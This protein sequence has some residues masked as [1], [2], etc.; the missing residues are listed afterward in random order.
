MIVEKKDDKKDDDSTEI[1][2]SKSHTLFKETIS[3]DK[4]I[5]EFDNDEILYKITPAFTKYRIFIDSF[6]EDERGLHEIFN[7]LWNADEK[8]EL[9]LRINSWGGIVKEG[10]NFF[11]II[12]NKFNGRTTTVLDSAGYSMG[13]LMFCSG[14][15]R[16]ATENCDLMF[17]DY[18]GFAWGKGGEI[19]D[20]VNHTAQHLRK[21]FKK[22]IVDQGFLSKKE[23][24]QMIIGK[25]YWMDVQEMCER[26]IATHVLV[27]GEEVKAKKY[28]KK[29]AKGNKNVKKKK[30][31]SKK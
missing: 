6:D 20:S 21:F 14:D 13:A 19:E 16:I 24:E 31:K 8:D 5:M 10:Q 22:V 3:E 23:F 1:K 30:K 2:N 28:L 29:L 25:D 17:H 18:S 11:N 9:E 15:K 7:I 12:K 26:G 4:E 27:K